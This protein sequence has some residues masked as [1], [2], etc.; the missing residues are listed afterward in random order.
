MA[1]VQ[2]YTCGDLSRPAYN[3]LPVWA[4]AAVVAADRHRIN[5]LRSLHAASAE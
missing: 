3:T 2:P 4:E 5:V 1:R